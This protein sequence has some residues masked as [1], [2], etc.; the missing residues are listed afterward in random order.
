[1]NNV[2]IERRRVETLCQRHSRRGIESINVNCFRVSLNQMS[3]NESGSKSWIKFGMNCRS[4]NLQRCS[5]G[6]IFRLLMIPSDENSHH[7]HFVYFFTDKI[8]IFVKTLNIIN[9]WTCI[10]NSEKKREFIHR[11]QGD[12]IFRFS[13]VFKAY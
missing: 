2:C 10:P 5:R 12:K 4:K 6:K 3:W 13:S 8:K 11:F 7:Q 9:Q 1:M